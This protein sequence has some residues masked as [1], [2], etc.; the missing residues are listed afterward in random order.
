MEL[1]DRN[2]LTEAEFLAA[3]KPGDF[4]RPCLTA[5]ILI[6]IRKKEG[7]KLLLIERGGH[8]FL[9]Q[10]ALP[11]GFVNID[12]TVEEAAC[13][14]LKE[15]T[16]LDHI[17]LELVNI[18]SNPK[19]D[20]RSWVVTGAYVGVAT[21]EEVVDMKPLDDAR[22]A[23]WFDVEFYRV[24]DHIYQMKLRKD[25]VVLSAKGKKIRRP[26]N[27]GG[28]FELEMLEQDGLAF[29]HGEIILYTLLR[30]EV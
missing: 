5:D 12:E 30:M 25:D 8:P 28:A 27:I 26:S 2:G 13:R 6:F 29:D 24:E 4:D 17:P 20:P 10:Y 19:R 23:A 22:G 1:R 21:E 7:L 16:N 11:G 3:Y 15:E 18:F 14:E 9:G